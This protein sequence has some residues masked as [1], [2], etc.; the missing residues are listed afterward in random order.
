MSIKGIDLRSKKQIIESFGYHVE[1]NA[2][3]VLITDPMVNEGGYHLQADSIH[4]A[5]EEMSALELLTSEE[6]YE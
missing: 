6:E 4:E 3:G 2:R 5:F 1:E